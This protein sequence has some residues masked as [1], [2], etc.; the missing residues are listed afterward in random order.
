MAEKDMRKTLVKALKPLDAIA[1]EN[2]IGE[3]TPDVECIDNW[4]ELKWLRAWPKRTGTPVRLDHPLLPG[5]KVWL[6]RRI[7]RGGRAWVVLQCR[8]EWLL[9]KGDVAAEFLGNSTYAELIHFAH[10][11][12][13]AGLNADELIEVLKND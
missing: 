13:Q 12:W 1:V 5:Q 10:R 7:R 3:G 2:S 9:F 11:V 4:L 6:K 8:R